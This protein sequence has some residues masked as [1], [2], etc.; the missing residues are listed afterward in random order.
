MH[1]LKDFFILT[2]IFPEQNTNDHITNE[3]MGPAWVPGLGSISKNR[4]C[5][6]ISLII[7]NLPIP[8]EY[9]PISRWVPVP[10]EKSNVP[11]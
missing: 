10:L 3:E 9:C 5:T 7:I 4:C 11:M 6:T 2:G 1:N 8:N